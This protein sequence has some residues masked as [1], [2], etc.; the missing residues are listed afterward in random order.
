[1][2]LSTKDQKEMHPILVSNSEKHIVKNQVPSF[3]NIIVNDVIDEDLKE[4]QEVTSEQ[5]INEFLPF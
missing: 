4:S 3:K 1:M 5:K 2:R